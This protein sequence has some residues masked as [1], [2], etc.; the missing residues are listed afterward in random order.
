MDGSVHETLKILLL[1]L[2]TIMNN[3]ILMNV[4]YF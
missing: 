3:L 4:P 1:I 2:D